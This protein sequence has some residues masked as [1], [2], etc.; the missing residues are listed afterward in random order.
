MSTTI[1]NA[2]N[3]FKLLRFQATGSRRFVFGRLKR[4]HVILE[5][6]KMIRNQ[7]WRTSQE[8]PYSNASFVNTRT[9]RLVF[10][11]GMFLFISVH[12]LFTRIALTFKS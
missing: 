12:F 6:E 10:Y 8:A 11:F 9:F 1:Y 4:L 7:Q 3:A 2:K 5:L